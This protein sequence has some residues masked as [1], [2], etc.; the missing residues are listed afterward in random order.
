[1][2]QNGKAAQNREKQEWANEKPKLDKARRLRGIYS[3][4]LDDQDYR[5]TFKNARRKLERPL[6]PAIPC[7]RAPNS[8]TE[9]FAQSEIASEKTPKRSM[10]LLWNLMNPQGNEWNLLSLKNNEVHLQ[11]E[12]LLQCLMTSW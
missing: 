12:D 7:K 10:V 8:I 4:D 2:D 6:V 3:L 5:E 1:M 11:A 9:V